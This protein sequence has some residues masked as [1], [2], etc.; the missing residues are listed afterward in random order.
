MEAIGRKVVTRYLVL[1]ILVTSL[2]KKNLQALYILHLMEALAM[3]LVVSNRKDR[4]F[5]E[6]SNYPCCLED[7]RDLCSHLDLRKQG[8]SNTRLMRV[9][10]S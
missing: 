9:L 7:I 10:L 6:T 3:I 1:P 2:G 8:Q 5:Q 4:V